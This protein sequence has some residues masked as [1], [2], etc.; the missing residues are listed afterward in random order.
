[1]RNFIR[2]FAVLVV[3]MLALQSCGNNAAR[4]AKL[5][6]DSGPVENVAHGGTFV[7]YT[8][9]YTV[10]WLNN[11]YTRSSEQ[12]RVYRQYDGEY[13]VDYNGENRLLTK[14]SSPIDGWIF[15]W[16]FD[17]NHYIS[18]DPTILGY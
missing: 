5:L 2:V 17:Y 16:R 10:D 11:T 18:D 1:M 4:D 14:I 6:W 7:G 8:R 12:Y 9:V 13:I 15:E 3:A